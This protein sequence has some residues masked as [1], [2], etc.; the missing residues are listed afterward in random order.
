V[1]ITPPAVDAAV[2][3]E[4]S[5]AKKLKLP[6]LATKASV[7]PPSNPTV[8]VAGVIKRHQSLLGATSTTPTHKKEC[9]SDSATKLHRAVWHFLCYQQG[10]IKHTPGGGELQWWRRVNA[11]MTLGF[12]MIFVHAWLVPRFYEVDDHT[13]DF[14]Y[15]LFIGLILFNQQLKR[16]TY[17]RVSDSI[18]S[19]VSSLNDDDARSILTRIKF[20]K[21]YLVGDPEN[22]KM[23]RF[24][25]LR[26][27]VMALIITSLVFVDKQYHLTTLQILAMF[28]DQLVAFLFFVS[29]GAMT[30]FT[31]DVAC[32]AL[33]CHSKRYREKVAGVAALMA[34]NDIE[35]GSLEIDVEIADL[36]SSFSV[37]Q[38]Q[39]NAFSEAFQNYFLVAEATIIPTLVAGGILLAGKLEQPQKG[40]TWGVA[41]FYLSHIYIIY[42]TA[43]LFLFARACSV[44][45][46][47]REIPVALHFI[48][49][50]IL[51][52]ELTNTMEGRKGKG[53]TFAQLVAHSNYVEQSDLAFKP[54]SIAIDGKLALYLSYIVATLA[55][56]FYIEF[57]FSS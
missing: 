45:S 5:L 48:R 47:L 11:K 6:P 52:H 57:M 43:L 42:W 38:R 50:D 3:G 16:L 18:L 14:Q 10:F 35:A 31:W 36:I 2:G 28:S 19:L 25:P 51:L 40:V 15:Q 46:S 24:I 55:F 34:N 37:L 41:V 8:A 9:R 32:E 56:T 22:R 39:S 17:A 44:T 26:N 4:A 53:A 23:D 27:F 20:T 13:L 49:N 30:F 7:P 33:L 12:P 1:A 54:Y 21:K 29:A